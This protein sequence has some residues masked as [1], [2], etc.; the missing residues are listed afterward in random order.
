MSR[1]TT[2]T[3]TPTLMTP[4]IESINKC[5]IEGNILYLPTEMLPNYTDLR[6]AMLNAGATYK[7]NTFIFPNAAQPYID[8]MTGGESVNIK[9][10]YQYF[11]TP[12]EIAKTMVSLLNITDGDLTI[13]EPSAGQGALIKEVQAKYDGLVFYYELMDINKGVLKNIP[14]AV[15]MGDDFLCSDTEIKYDRII[16]NPPFSKNQDIEHICR[17]YEHLEKGGRL[18][19]LCSTHYVQTTGRKEQ[20]FREFLADVEATEQ[21]LAARAFKESGTNI[22][23]MMIIID[24]N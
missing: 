11:P 7:R 16:A 18:V 14:N 21:P 4:L 12:P 9:K 17:M 2:G 23:T 24:K 5:R 19:T 22:P 20:G 8:R 13:L 3:P 15:Y 10:E 1:Q 6:K